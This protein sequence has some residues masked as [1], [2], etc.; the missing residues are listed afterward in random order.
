MLKFC[1][2][3]KGLFV[4]KQII[5]IVILQVCILNCDCVKSKGVNC[6]LLQNFLDGLKAIILQHVKFQ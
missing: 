2:I 5:L 3:V 1:E 6:N 4:Y